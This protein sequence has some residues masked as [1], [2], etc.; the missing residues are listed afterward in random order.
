MGCIE[1]WGIYCSTISNTISNRSLTS[2][3]MWAKKRAKV[4]PTRSTK[5]SVKNS[6]P[7]EKM[8][9]LS[10]CAYTYI[11]INIFSPALTIFVFLN[12]GMECETPAGINQVHFSCHW[13]GCQAIE[14][15]LTVW[16]TP[17]SHEFRDEGVVSIYWNC[18]NRA[19]R[20]CVWGW[21]YKVSFGCRW[22][23]IV[24]GFAKLVKFIRYNTWL[25][26]RDLLGHGPEGRSV[27]LR[28]ANLRSIFILLIS[29]VRSW[30]MKIV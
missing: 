1:N 10:M 3:E 21:P 20:I 18:H 29:W 27:H 24:K 5:V 17:R 4:I 2:T 23:Y 11:C 8:K 30:N 6:V 16:P 26:S 9:C 15:S 19:C 28:I 22:V 14:E 7:S 13:S 12:W 25:K